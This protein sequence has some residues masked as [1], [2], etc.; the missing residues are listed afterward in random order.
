MSPLFCFKALRKSAQNCGLY[1]C[2]MSFPIDSRINASFFRHWTGSESDPHILIV[3]VDWSKVYRPVCFSWKNYGFLLLSVESFLE[4][5]ELSL[6]SIC[7]GLCN[8]FFSVS[9]SIT[10]TRLIRRLVTVAHFFP[11]NDTLRL[12]HATCCT[13]SSMC[14]TC[15]KPE[16]PDG[17]HSLENMKPLH[18]DVMN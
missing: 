17:R 18:T 11:L 5:S 2:R 12:S 4:K 15:V 1:S 16:S 8:P 7:P 10:A 14:Y 3:D 13:V 6:S 9:W